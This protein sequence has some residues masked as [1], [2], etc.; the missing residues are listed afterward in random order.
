MT[1]HRLHPIYDETTARQWGLSEPDPAGLILY[2]NCDRCAEHAEYPIV[3]LDDNHLRRMWDEMIEAEHNVGYY[4]T[5]NEAEAGKHLY[6]I[7]LFME[8]M[9]GIDPWQDLV[10]LSESLR[11][12]L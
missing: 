7:A 2:D 1:M 11:R 9:L 6:H 4:R 3:S 12:G 8:R 10:S 5:Q